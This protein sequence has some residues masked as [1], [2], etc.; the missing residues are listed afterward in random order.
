MS[1]NF[2]RIIWIFFLYFEIVL[3]DKENKL[4]YSKSSLRFLEETDFSSF[5][6]NDNVLFVLLKLKENLISHRHSLFYLIECKWEFIKT[7][8]LP[9]PRSSGRSTVCGT[10]L[11]ER[12]EMRWN[13]R[14]TM[15]FPLWPFPDTRWHIPR[16]ENR[17]KSLRSSLPFSIQLH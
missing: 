15:D 8:T 11:M 10:W 3:R 17:E 9:F 1:P 6:Q 7:V 16:R 13:S 4:S 14:S 12:D 2:E 5:F